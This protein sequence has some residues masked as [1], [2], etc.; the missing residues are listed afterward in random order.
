MANLWCDF[1]SSSY[2][3]LLIAVF[4]VQIWYHTPKKNQINGIGVDEANL[5][6]KKRQSSQKNRKS[7]PKDS[8]P[9]SASEDDDIRIIFLKTAAKYD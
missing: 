1:D 6:Q 2:Q 4:L 7:P 9:S 8:S 5:E 3:F